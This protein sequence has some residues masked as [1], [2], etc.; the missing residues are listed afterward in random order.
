M[1]ADLDIMIFRS[2]SELVKYL[3][4]KISEIERKLED[5]SKMLESVKDRKSKYERIKKLVEEISGEASATLSTTIY[6]SGL[7]VIIDPKPV[8]EYEVLESVYKA[9]SDKLNVLKRIRDVV[10]TY[11]GK[12]LNEEG[13]NIIVEFRADVPIK[14]MLKM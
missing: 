10:D 8:D 11:L 9:L 2:I 14:I 1:S 12:Y 7:R 6:I 13:I 3:D 4:D 5:I